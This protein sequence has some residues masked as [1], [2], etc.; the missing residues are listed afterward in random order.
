MSLQRWRHLDLDPGMACG[1]LC[2]QP[3]QVSF[4]VNPER[5]KV[6]DHDNPCNPLLPQAGYRPSQVGLPP[7][8]KRRFDVN[9]R[10]QSGKLA[11]DGAHPFIR[12]FDRGAVSEDDESL[13]R[14]GIAW[15][16]SERNHLRP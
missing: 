4:Q 14:I 1:R 11:G 7:F 15:S 16:V 9:K 8:Q 6:G 2:Y 3:R 10:T 13:Q 5:Q 12:A